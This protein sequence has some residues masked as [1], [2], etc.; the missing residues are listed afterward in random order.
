M[1]RF[2]GF[3]VGTS[4]EGL[5]M[6]E[7]SVLLSLA[8]LVTSS[9]STVEQRRQVPV[10]G[11]MLDEGLLKPGWSDRAALVF[12]VASGN[13]SSRSLGFRNTLSL[14]SDKNLFFVDVFGFRAANTTTAR[15]A[16]GLT[17][18]QAEIF[19]RRTTRVSAE[20]YLIR[21]KL[22]RRVARRLYAFGAGGWERN[23]FSGIDSRSFIA[24]GV[25]NIWLESPRSLWRTDYGLARIRQVNPVAPDRSEPFAALRTSSKLW[26]IVGDRVRLEND[27]IAD[28]NL[29]RGSDYRIDTIQSASFGVAGRLRLR[30]SF[31]LLYANDRPLAVDFVELPSG[32]FTGEQVQLR[33][34]HFDTFLTVAFVVDF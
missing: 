1:G 24:F 9:P 26:A 27:F 22:D 13:A 34:G 2:L 4:Q 7:V 6:I 14:R 17:V 15:V 21:T 10:V 3:G 23:R 19:E 11:T 33:L 25:G 28:F 32:E 20:R 5:A 31:Q 30:V 8:A 12:A 18:E 29:Q 16:G